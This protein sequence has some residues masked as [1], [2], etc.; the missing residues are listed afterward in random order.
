MARQIK[1]GMPGI[2]FV[3]FISVPLVVEL[4]KGRIGKLA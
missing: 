2:R 4:A 3:Q 1:S